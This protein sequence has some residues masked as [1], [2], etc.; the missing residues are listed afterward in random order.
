MHHRKHDGKSIK[1]H[2]GFS[3][4]DSGKGFSKRLANRKVRQLKLFDFGTQK[5]CWKTLHEQ[6]DICD[7]NFRL[8]SVGELMRWVEKRWNDPWSWWQS[9]IRKRY[10]ENIQKLIMTDFWRYRG[11]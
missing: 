3:D 2:P 8:H 6:W 7:H 5:A 1:K 4:G 11:K 10:G 9:Y